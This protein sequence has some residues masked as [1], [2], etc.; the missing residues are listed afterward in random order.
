L[1]SETGKERRVLDVNVLAIFLVKNHPG[2]KFVSPILEE[3]LRGAYIPLL[4]DILP[5]R[6]Y[7]IMTRRW[8]CSEK[9]SAEA[10]KHFIKAYDGPRYLSLEKET[11]VES[12]RISEDLKH[13]MFDCIYLAFALQEQADAII[14]TDTDFKRLCKHLELQYINP[15][16]SEV[17]ER[18]KGQNIER[19]ER[20]QPCEL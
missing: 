20:K 10:V 12:F 4:M 1:A 13:D 14:T 15:V 18:F 2:N 11:I 5:V 16:P 6:A 9:E 19:N 17:L 8:R 7:W 3:G